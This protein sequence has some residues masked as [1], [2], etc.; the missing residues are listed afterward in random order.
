MLDL[1]AT[2]DSAAER[3]SCAFGFAV[4]SWRARSGLRQKAALPCDGRVYRDNRVLALLRD[5]A[6]Y[7]ELDRKT[8]EAL[9]APLADQ[10][11][12]QMTTPPQRLFAEGRAEGVQVGEANG[13]RKGKAD[14]LIVHT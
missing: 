9:I 2:P 13:L 3:L 5:I 6:E 4:L 14:L 8:M 12:S 10:E 11:H 7:L 1:G